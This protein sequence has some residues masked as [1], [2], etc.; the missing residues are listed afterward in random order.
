MD[1][2]SHIFR[3][4]QYLR[5]SNVGLREFGGRGPTASMDD[6]RELQFPAQSGDLV[7]RE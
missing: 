2:F 5:L 7:Q 4:S 3:G 6:V 1:G